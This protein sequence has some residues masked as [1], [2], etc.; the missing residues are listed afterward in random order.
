MKLTWYVWSSKAAILPAG[1]C[2]VQTATTLNLFWL[3]WHLPQRYYHARRAEETFRSKSIHLQQY[4]RQA[5]AV[6]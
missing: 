3:G 6:R 2:A 5:M 1:W 4:Q